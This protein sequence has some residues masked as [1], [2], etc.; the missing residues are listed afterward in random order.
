M[1]KLQ[2]K[3]AN[4]PNRLLLSNDGDNDL[5]SQYRARTAT[6]SS[7]TGPGKLSPMLDRSK[8]D[9]K[10]SPLQSD[11]SEQFPPAAKKLSLTNGRRKSENPNHNTIEALAAIQDYHAG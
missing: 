9:I 2:Q 7:T 4:E 10:L 11:R 6:G 5:D 1:I 8:P 3:S